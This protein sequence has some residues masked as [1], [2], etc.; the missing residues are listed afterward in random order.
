MCNMRDFTFFQ[1]KNERK[2]SMVSSDGDFF[3][4]SNSLVTLFLCPNLFLFVAETMRIP[5]PMMRFPCLFPRASVPKNPQKIFS[6]KD[7]LQL[8]CSLIY[9]QMLGVGLQFVSVAEILPGCSSIA[10]TPL[11]F[12]SCKGKKQ[13][14]E[15][16]RGCR[17]LLVRH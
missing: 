17:T 13:R 7:L 4:K 1:A 15:K 2:L 16:C 8:F 10:N 11:N 12:I 3:D 9:L 14:K 5:N 6:K